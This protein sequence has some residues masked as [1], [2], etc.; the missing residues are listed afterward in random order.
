ML[1]CEALNNVNCFLCA[2]ANGCPLTV[3]GV[4]SQCVVH[5]SLLCVFTWMGEMQGTECWVWDTMLGHMSS[6]SLSLQFASKASLF[7][8]KEQ[9]A[10]HCEC[11]EA[12]EPKLTEESSHCQQ[13]SI[14]RAWALKEAPSGQITQT[15][16]AQHTV[17]LGLN[18]VWLLT[19]LQSHE[20][21]ACLTLKY[22]L[23]PTWLF[24]KSI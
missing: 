12:T 7:Y 23:F 22:K 17:K 24:P 16:R 6:L 9:A 10:L 3:L 15:P 2:T 11:T 20:L 14:L 8:S 13:G 5:Y 18:D 21:P 4:C 19:T 1:S